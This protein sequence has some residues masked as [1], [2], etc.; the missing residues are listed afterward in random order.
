ML[1]RCIASYKYVA[2]STNPEYALL[3]NWQTL[4]LSLPT[5]NAT[6][7]MRA[8]R[9]LKACGAAVLRDGVYL[10]PRQEGDDTLAAIGRDVRDSGGTAH[11]LQTAVNAE[12]EGDYRALFDRSAD[13]AELMKDVAQARSLLTPDSAMD[14]LKQTRKL[15]KRF[16]QI[17]IIDFFAAEAQRQADA[18]LTELE[19][20]ANRALSPDEPHPADGAIPRLQAAEYRGRKWATRAR[21]W[22]DRL[23]SAWLIRRFIDP[24]AHFLWLDSL[25]N[26]PGD[27]LGFDFDGATFSHVG[28]KV[29]FETLLA[30]FCLQSPAL[31]RLGSIVHYLDAGGVQPAEA[32]GV[33]QVLAGLRETIVDDDQLLA[34]ASSVFDGL[35]ASFSKEGST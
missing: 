12:E 6:A 7:R 16:V 15:R 21:P 13:Y 31:D 14:T 22:V 29:T 4:I 33:E 23:A 3:M 5:E 18:T 24:D 2:D 34:L 30:A 9:A 35:V 17:S 26:C 27:A 10:L 1:K 11:L 32:A 19:E 8:W 20:G 28:A 25:A